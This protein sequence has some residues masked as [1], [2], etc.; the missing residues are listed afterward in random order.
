MGVGGVNGRKNVENATD[1]VREQ[2]RKMKSMR[3]GTQNE[4]WAHE[5]MSMLNWREVTSHL[6]DETKV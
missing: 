3:T 6:R 5:R 1:V 4:R 2:Q